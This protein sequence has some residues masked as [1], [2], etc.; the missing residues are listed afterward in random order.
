MGEPPVVYFC[1]VKSRH[2]LRLPADALAEDTDN[3]F[4]VA[5]L[6]RRCVLVRFDHVA[7]IIA[8]ADHSIMC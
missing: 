4:G 5:V 6:V 1:N 7:S 8:N 2:W 3:E